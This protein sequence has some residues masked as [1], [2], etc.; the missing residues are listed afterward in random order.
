MK[1]GS[2]ILTLLIG[3][4][5]ATFGQGGRGSGGPQTGIALNIGGGATAGTTPE[6]QTR[7]W[8]AFVMRIHADGLV[9]P[10]ERREVARYL[11]RAPLSLRSRLLLSWFS[12][13]TRI[14]GNTRPAVVS[15]IVSQW[16]LTD[17]GAAAAWVNSLPDRDR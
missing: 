17:P 12:L 7:G 2:L 14:G 5:A 3:L 15:G 13:K 4:T 8:A 10:A 9:S 11:S 1:V 6:G 16:T